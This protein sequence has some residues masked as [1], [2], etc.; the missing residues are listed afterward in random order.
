M[1]LLSSFLLNGSSFISVPFFGRKLLNANADDAV[2]GCTQKAV[3]CARKITRDDNQNNRGT[4]EA[5][6]HLTVL[7]GVGPATA[8]AILCLVRPDIFCYM[9]D[10]VIDC[11]EKKR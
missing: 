4:Q 1:F 6:D 8:S 7:K 5:L 9:Y 11:F 10:E 3:N 2:V